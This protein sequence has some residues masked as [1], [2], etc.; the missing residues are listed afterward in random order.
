MA[1][2]R[3]GE[4]TDRQ[5]RL[6]VALLLLADDE[7][8]G[9]ADPRFLRAQAFAFSP[10]PPDAEEVARDLEALPYVI[11]YEV[12][13]VRYYQLANW[14]AWQ[15]LEK[16][17]TSLL[18]PP[19]PEVAVPVHVEVKTGGRPRVGKV[20]VR[21][22]DFREASENEVKG[23][24]GKEVEVKEEK[25]RKLP[26]S[27]NLFK[28]IEKDRPFYREKLKERAEAIL[29]RVEARLPASAPPPGPEVLR[30]LRGLLV[31]F[32]ARTGDPE[33]SERAVLEAAGKAAEGFGANF[34]WRAFTDAL[35]SNLTRGSL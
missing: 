3:L 34:S 7:G 28:K 32:D 19:P 11:L 14:G 4:L 29:R 23:N 22:R 1:D 17:T 27:K 20:W 9:L 18:P 16:P 13:G 31:T 8:R 21:P 12:E 5:F 6:W 24:E 30:T 33:A 10:N 25:E 2:P 15:R 26:N 35:I